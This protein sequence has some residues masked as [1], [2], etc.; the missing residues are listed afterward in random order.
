MVSRR[1][2]RIGAFRIGEGRVANWPGRRF[3]SG[4][5]RERRRC[6]AHRSEGRDKPGRLV[7]A[8]RRPSRRHQPDSDRHLLH[9]R[10]AEVWRASALQ[11]TGRRPGDPRDGRLLEPNLRGPDTDRRRW[12][13]GERVSVPAVISVVHPER[14]P[15]HGAEHAASG[16][17]PPALVRLGYRPVS[18]VAVG[19][20]ASGN[21]GVARDRA[22][23]RALCPHRFQPPSWPVPAGQR[24][25]PSRPGSEMAG[26][27]VQRQ[28]DAH[29]LLGRYSRRMEARRTRI[30][31]DSARLQY[32]GRDGSHRLAL[33]ACR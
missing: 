1:P 10:F 30:P 2:V 28:C 15:S 24:H 31:P 33:P 19:L 12:R 16:S 13:T 22:G 11:D 23:S 17:Q 21:A 8:S 25:D 4:V 3:G 18:V 32:A 14:V 9:G 6:H 5:R 29:D 20:P 7:R 26:Y 27:R